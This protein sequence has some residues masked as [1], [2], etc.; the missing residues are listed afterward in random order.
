[1][2]TFQHSDP[3]IVEAV[4]EQLDLLGDELRAT[5]QE[6]NNEKQIVRR[7]ALANDLRRLA[8]EVARLGDDLV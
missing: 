4:A 1:M 2:Q 6:P 5:V 3:E 8:E 7:Y